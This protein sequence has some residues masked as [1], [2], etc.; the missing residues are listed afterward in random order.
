MS[1]CDDKRYTY[2]MKMNFVNNNRNNNNNNNNDDDKRSSVV[3]HRTQN[4]TSDEYLEIERYYKYIR[5]GYGTR[6]LKKYFEIPSNITQIIGEVDKKNVSFKKLFIVISVLLNELL[7][8][9]IQDKNKNGCTD[10][11]ALDEKASR[12]RKRNSNGDDGDDGDG[13]GGGEDDDDDDNVTFKT[14]N[15]MSKTEAYLYEKIKTRHSVIPMEIFKCKSYGV[16][17][18]VAMFCL[19]DHKKDIT[20]KMFLAIHNERFKTVEDVI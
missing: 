4:Q 15:K 20:T 17:M 16:R 8:K 13:G 10:H 18:A 7:K 5:E 19:H 11:M 2:Y 12:K 3:K 9:T 6:R 14:S 1:K